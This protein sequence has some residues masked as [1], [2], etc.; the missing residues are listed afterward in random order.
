[1]N[2]KGVS[3]EGPSITSIPKE[4][5]SIARRSKERI[6]KELLEWYG[7]DTVEDYLLVAKKAILNNQNEL[8]SADEGDQ[9][10]RPTSPSNMPESLSVDSYVSSNVALKYQESKQETSLLTA[11]HQY[12]VHTSPNFSFGFVP[13]MIGNQLSSF[14]S[15]ESQ[16]RDGFHVLSLVVSQPF[17]PASYYA[18]FYHS[19]ADGDG[20]MSPF[21][22]TGPTEFNGYVP[23]L[24]I[25]KKYEKK[26]AAHQGN[27][28]DD[29]DIAVPGARDLSHTFRYPKDRHQFLFEA[30]RQCQEAGLNDKLNSLSYKNCGALS[31]GVSKPDI[32]STNA[33]KVGKRKVRRRFSIW[34]W[35]SFRLFSVAGCVFIF[36]Q[37]NYQDHDREHSEQPVLVRA[38]RDTDN[39]RIRFAITRTTVDVESC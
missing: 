5:Q 10:D 19:G 21:H 14:E 33:R 11:G 24:D 27:Q 1:M 28:D 3:S 2:N 20:R 18:Q 8:A 7:Y 22:S 32:N 9:P 13:P 30:A 38:Y 36:L 31:Y 16:G 25:R 23:M 26:L 4:G 34:I 17:D 6:P 15:N 29:K 12:L 35:V 39:G 37:H